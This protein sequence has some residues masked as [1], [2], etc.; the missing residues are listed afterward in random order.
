MENK[1]KK[2]GVEVVSISEEMVK[3]TKTDLNNLF[4]R[5]ES[6][7]RGSRFE[8]PKRVT[9]RIAKLRFHKD[10]PVIWYGNVREKRDAETEKMVAYMDIKLYEQDK[11]ETVE[12]LGFLNSPNQYKVVKKSTDMRE[13]TESF[14]TF[15]PENPN[16]ADESFSKRW[17]TQETEEEVIRREYVSVV[18]VLDGPY[19]GQVYTVIDNDALN[20]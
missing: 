18:E 7:E 4:D 5:L 15:I 1:E 3:I 14:G 20:F 8:K 11:K 16:P 9:E 13:F 2:L 12:Y 19:K 17:S 6:L 10:K